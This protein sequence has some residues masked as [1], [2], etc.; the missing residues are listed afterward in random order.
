MRLLEGG[1]GMMGARTLI[2]LLAIAILLAAP[3]EAA[4]SYYQGSSGETSFNG[5][6]GGLVLLDPLLTFSASDLGSFGLFNASGTG[7]D[8]LGFD[9]VN[10][11]TDF[12]VN[13]GKLTATQPEQ[14]VTIN[15]PAAGVYAFGIHITLT[16][17]FATWCIDVTPSGCGYGF[18][19]ISGS[20][21]QFFGFVSDTPVTASLYIH[22]QG[23]SPYIVLTDFEAFSTPEPRTM[24]LVGLGLIILQA[25]SRKIRRS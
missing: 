8:F 2:L 22:N 16:S 19:T 11:P 4:T 15:F 5:A 14:K 1:G 13:S 12:A 25:A 7:I 10:A 20:A 3:A 23:S 21:P 18:T 24:L 9:S 17:G 6:V